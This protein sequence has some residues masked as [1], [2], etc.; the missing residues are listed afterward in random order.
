MLKPIRALL[1]ALIALF[2]LPA[3]AAEFNDAQKKE[4][5]DII[6][7]YL[8]DNPEVVRDAMQEL[9][10][11]QQEAEDSARTDILK[12]MAADIF[13]SKDDLVGG[14]P[15][16]KV[17]MVE[18]FDYNCGY[19]KRAFPDVMKMIDADKDLKLVMKEF[20]ILGPGSVYAARAA[21]A[22]RKQG[23]YWEYHMAMMAHEGRIDEA[24]ADQI[25]EASGLDVKKLKADME[26]D[27][28]NQVIT[29]NMQ[30]ADSLKI[31]GT[32]AFI[33]DETVIPGAVGYEALAAVVKQIRDN[34]GCKLC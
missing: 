24:V 25:A 20:P 8:L 34:G 30:L 2:V 14:N 18:F 16:G 17:T 26:A 12:T 5:G 19:C 31:Q 32:P 27:E 7:Q 9:E 6:R 13:R 28:V 33:I 4:L 15:K 11:K 22:S 10:R 1:I 29:R 23:K 21:L 3:Q